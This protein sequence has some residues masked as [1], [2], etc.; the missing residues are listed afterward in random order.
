MV[1]EMAMVWVTT[2]LDS[3]GQ[4]V[5]VG[6]QLVM[7]ISVVVKTVEVL[8]LWTGAVETAPTEETAGLDWPT[9]EVPGTTEVGTTEVPGATEVGATEVPGAEAGTEVP[10]AE[11]GTEVPGA[12]AGT[13]VPGAVVPGTPVPEGVV[14]QGVV[15]GPAGAVVGAAP[16]EISGTVTGTE[17]G[18]VVGT[19]TTG[20]ETGTVEG[21]LGELVEVWP[22]VLGLQSNPIEYIPNPQSSTSLWSGI[23]QLT[24]VAPPHWSLE[25]SVPSDPHLVVKEHLL[26]SGMPKLKS[27]SVSLSV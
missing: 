24:E 4:L 20:T 13:E 27:T 9:T 6:A 26:P 7:V 2:V 25:T 5:T 14:V 18:V 8:K 1:V 21:E 23:D 17:T 10:G 15:V 3:A 12:E 16:V 19:E 22:P 11:A